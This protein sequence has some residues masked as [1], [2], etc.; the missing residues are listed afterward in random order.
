MNFFCPTIDHIW[1]VF[2]KP[3][4]CVSLRL[5]DIWL[6][7]IFTWHFVHHTCLLKSFHLVLCSRKQLFQGTERVNVSLVNSRTRISGFFTFLFKIW[8]S[9]LIYFERFSFVLIGF[10]GTCV[11]SYS[12]LRFVW[13]L[14]MDFTLLKIENITLYLIPFRY[15]TVHSSID[16]C[17]WA[18]SD[19]CHNFGLSR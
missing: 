6:W 4:S 2:L 12:L 10:W 18:S 19:I 14:V 3:S 1:F 13:S 9:D 17:G 11:L 5:S 15:A 8:V 16:Q 7:A